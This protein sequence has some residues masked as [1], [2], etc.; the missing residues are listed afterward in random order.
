MV[1][2]H[3]IDQPL[4]WR[5][6]RRVFVNSMSDLFHPDLPDEVIDRIFDVMEEAPRHVFQVLTKRP[7]RMQNYTMQRY[8]VERGGTGAPP[9]I[10]LGTS[11]E[12]R[13]TVTERVVPLTHTPAAV[14]F[15]SCEPLL[16]PLGRI[17]RL[18]HLHWVIVGGES[19]PGARPMHPDWAREIRDQCVTYRVPFFF[20]QWGR[21]SF[22]CRGEG[23][24]STLW[25][26]RDRLVSVDG[27]V[28]CS[29]GS[30]GVGAVPMS[31]VGKKKAGRLL[32]GRTWDEM[33][34]VAGV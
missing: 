1:V 21:W 34:E 32:D 6:P 7:I 33:P 29:W 24:F 11:V 28:H 27:N 18:A 25:N 5:K 19:G 3:A 26:D 10:W 14:R 2:E 8:Y 22:R 4:R 23:V 17:P 13:K 16:G 12:D 30:A 31:E 15:L 20:K 9:H